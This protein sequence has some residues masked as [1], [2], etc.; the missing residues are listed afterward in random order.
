M[1][2]YLFNELQQLIKRVPRQKIG[3]LVQ[4]KEITAE[5]TELLNDTLEASCLYDNQIE[6]ASFMA[7]RE[8]NNEFSLYRILSTKTSRNV[9]GLSG[10]NFGSDELDGYVVKDIR[11]NNEAAQTLV[12]RLFENAGVEGWE[13]RV[14]TP[15][16][17]ITDNFYYVTVR[18]ALKQL[19][20]HGIE[21]TFSCDLTESGIAKK[22]LDA[23]DKIGTNAGTRFT[24]GDKALTVEKEIERTNIVTSLIGRGR[25]E[26]VGDGY[27]RRI[28]FDDIEWSKAKG[29][30]LDKPKGQ[31]F[32]ED[33]EATLKYGIPVGSGMRKREKVIIFDD[34]DSTVELI[35]LTHAALIENQ[36]P[37]VQFSSTV[38][39]AEYIGN[40]VTI[41]RHDRGYHYETRIYKQERDFIR[42][43]K[44]VYLGDNLTSNSKTS[45]LSAVQSIN[46][47][48]KTKMTFFQST[49]IS[50]FQDDIMRGA[51][52]EGGSIYQVNGIEA[53]VSDSREVYEYVW[54]NGKNIPSSSHFMTANSEGISFK[55]CKKGEWK[56]I[57]DVH[58]GTSHTAW[59]IDGTFNANFIMAGILRGILIEGALLKTFYT[60]GNQKQYQAVMDHGKFAIQTA[61]DTPN[62]INYSDKNW[63]DKVQG[64]MIAEFKGTYDANTNRANG[65]AIIKAKNQIFSINV[66]GE[67]FST[68]IFQIPADAHADNLKYRM[69][70][71]GSFEDGQVTFNDKV[72]FK[73]GFEVQGET[74]FHN[75]VTM[76]SNLAVK[77]GLT[78]NNGQAVYPGQ[79]GGPSGGG[80]GTGG[81]PDG[82]TSD[83][84]K[85]AWQI[86]DILLANK[87]TKQAACGILGNMYQET[88]YT[89][90]PDTRQVGG[91]AYGLVQWDGSA[92]PLVGPATYD[93]KVYVQN[94]FNAANIKEPVESLRGQVQLLLWTFGTSQWMGVIEPATVAGLKACTDPRLAARAFERNY[95]RPAATHP[96]REDYAVQ[97]YNRFKDLKPTQATGEAGLKHLESLMNTRVGNGQCYALSAEYSGFLG[98]CGMGSGTKYSFSHVI[99]DTTAASNIG[100]GYD[101]G[102]V[103][104]KVIFN[105]SLDQLVVGAIINWT[106]GASVGGPNAWTTD[107][108][109]GHTG[110]IRGIKGSAI[111]TYEQNTEYGQV[112]A[113][114]VRGFINAGSIASICI[115]PK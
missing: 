102:A 82:L 104:W 47:M 55:E 46:T 7:I 90:D 18:E 2:L 29:D 31:I 8:D 75:N 10:V 83:V 51:G 84:E 112:V 78:I 69:R 35:K 34:C 87:F 28:E 105:P 9:L 17:N 23:Y 30:P 21:F 60:E 109:Y 3:S 74:L 92:Y 110:V 49:E 41:H 62:E 52:K 103:G 106:Q 95:E 4:Y 61:K 88:G 53:G 80:G 79:G 44:K 37:L 54:M 73:K 65:A 19:Q 36:R 42:N 11:P 94:L 15:L 76:N 24:Y 66:M 6:K 115:P 96:E 114:C 64:N 26:E 93:G 72:I 89:F 77:G 107:P 45:T 40:T 100:S 39:G 22:Y 86:Y 101:W 71:K 33:P 57:K 48:E 43:I 108:T 13:I 32:L 1:M 50:K 99:G 91:P 85:R 20:T 81:I 25:G 113:K 16:P 111:L 12:N 38:L 70:G 27:G 97:W 98:G 59:T 67:E 63:R 58:N 56:T 68:S 5:R 14:H